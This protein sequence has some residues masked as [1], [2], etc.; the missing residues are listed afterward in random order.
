MS[1]LPF[2]VDKLALYVHEL[3]TC[4]HRL[5]FCVNKLV[6]C[7]HKLGFLCSENAIQW[8]Q[9]NT[10]LAF[11]GY[12]LAFCANKFVF[13]TNKLVQGTEAWNDIKI[14]NKTC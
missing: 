12:K 13:C 8:S 1:K 2:C 10:L 3:V 6:S 4:V 7:V 5:A 11:C 9:I 14:N